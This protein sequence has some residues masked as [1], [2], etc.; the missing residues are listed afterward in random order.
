MQLV[1]WEIQLLDLK[2]KSSN[3]NEFTIDADHKGTG[4]SLG[5]SNHERVTGSLW[6]NT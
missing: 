3:L 5:Y 6:P 4:S 1:L 2:L